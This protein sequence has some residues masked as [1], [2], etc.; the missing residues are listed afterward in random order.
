MPERS[1]HDLLLRHFASRAEAKKRDV[2]IDVIGRLLD[3]RSTYDE[4]PAT[5]SRGF[6]T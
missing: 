4:L 3:L 6:S 5:Y 2:D 1:E